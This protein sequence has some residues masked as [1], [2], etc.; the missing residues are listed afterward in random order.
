MY[1]VTALDLALLFSPILYYTLLK[2]TTTLYYH[3]SL[4]STVLMLNSVLYEQGQGKAWIKNKESARDLQVNLT[5]FSKYY[6][7]I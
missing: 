5:E 1:Y 7:K 4:Y 6:N 2:Y 3:T